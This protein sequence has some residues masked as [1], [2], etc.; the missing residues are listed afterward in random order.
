MNAQALVDT[1]RTM[2]ADDKGLLSMDESNPICDKRSA[3]LGIPQT[4]EARRPLGV[5]CDH[6]GSRFLHLR[7]VFGPMGLGRP[8]AVEEVSFIHGFEFPK[9]D[10]LH[11]LLL[12]IDD[13]WRRGIIA[14]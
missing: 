6:P 14:F 4:E 11:F 13:R 3:G 1:A 8:G 7:L 12:Q 10:A 5:D 2:L 9:P